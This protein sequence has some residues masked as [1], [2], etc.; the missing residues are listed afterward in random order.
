MTR[1]AQETVNAES[2]RQLPVPPV[3]IQFRQWA[4]PASSLNN[5][6]ESG[7]TLRNDRNNRSTA[8]SGQ[9]TAIKTCPLSIV[10][11]SLL[12]IIIKCYISYIYKSIVLHTGERAVY[13]VCRIYSHASSILETG[14]PGTTGRLQ[15]IQVIQRRS[16]GGT[17]DKPCPNRNKALRMKDRRR[18]T[19]NS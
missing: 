14:G 11:C 6:Q 2:T 3:S 12:N 13:T 7:I 17:K 8:D 15:I 19:E 16:K 1:M 9:R 18:K 4:P 10:Y 5:E